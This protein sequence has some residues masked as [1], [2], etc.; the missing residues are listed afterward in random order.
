[1]V[2]KK[3]SAAHDE[4]GMESVQ[5]YAPSKGSYL[6][7][8]LVII[9]LLIN[10]Y[11]LSVVTSLKSV[12]VARMGGSENYKLFQKVIK[13]DGFKQ[14]NKMQLEGML[15]QFEQPTEQPTQ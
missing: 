4:M 5:E 15:K 13:T 6:T 14:M 9:S 11:V 12:D 10:L 1:M 3:K 2:F 7:V 8:A